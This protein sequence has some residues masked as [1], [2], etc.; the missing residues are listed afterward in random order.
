MARPLQGHACAVPGAANDGQVPRWPTR[1][2]RLGAAVR[3]IR[4]A[5]HRLVNLLTAHDAHPDRCGQLTPSA[6]HARRGQTAAG[7]EQLVRHLGVEG[8]RRPGSRAGARPRRK[9]NMLATP[10][11]VAG[12]AMNPSAGDENRNTQ[13]GQQQRLLPGQRDR[14][15]RLGRCQHDLLALHP[16]V[17]RFAARIRSCAQ[18]AV[19]ARPRAGDRW[20]ARPVLVARGRA[21]DDR[22]IWQDGPGARLLCA[23]ENALPAAHAA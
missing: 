10:G 19:P 22:P 17:S 21:G 16:A 14:L 2:N 6:T 15:D 9:R 4:P 18:T 8:R 7:T 5:R 23:R 20:P 13:S 12:H 3:T 1:I 11:P